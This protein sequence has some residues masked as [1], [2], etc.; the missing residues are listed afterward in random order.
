MLE[1]VQ[2]L[3]KEFFLYIPYEELQ[4][5][6]AEFAEQLKKDL[7]GTNPLFVVMLNGAFMFAAELMKNYDFPAE[8]SFVKYSSYAGLQSSGKV[9]KLLGLTNNVEGRDIVIIEDIV[10]SGLTMKSM[11]DMFKEQ[12]VNSVKIAALFVKPNCLIHDVKVDYPIIEI[13]D[14]FIVGFGLDYNG[15]GR[16]FKNVYK[17][18]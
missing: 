18:K 2:V 15:Y 11:V 8:I 5:K 16:N 12:K 9:E 3:D 1:T 14:D 7:A 13:V 10:E 6:I 17:L 4:R